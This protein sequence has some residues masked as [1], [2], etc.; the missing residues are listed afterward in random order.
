MYI[1]ILKEI[2]TASALRLVLK[3]KRQQ[4]QTIEITVSM[5]EW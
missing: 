4:Q 3:R 2:I 1:N 5:E